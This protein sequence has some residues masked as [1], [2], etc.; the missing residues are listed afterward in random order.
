MTA[1]MILGRFIVMGPDLGDGEPSFRGTQLAVRE[2]VEQ[3]A[4]GQYWDTVITQSRRTLSRRA[5]A[6]ALALCV[7]ALLIETERLRDR[8][9][10][11]RL[12]LGEHIG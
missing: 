4:S 11:T 2:V 9:D 8:E 6:E 3:I 1:R 10:Q 5:I 7:D 12:A